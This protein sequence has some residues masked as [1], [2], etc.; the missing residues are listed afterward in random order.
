MITPVDLT[1]ALALRDREVVAL[2]GG[3][4][5]TTAMYLLC[6]E[7]LAR[8]RPAIAS[9]TARFTRPATVRAPMIVDE[10][11][12]RLVAEARRRLGSGEPWLV[13]AAGRGSKGRLLPLSYETVAALAAG[14]ADLV[15]L[16]ADGSALRPL[17][18]PAAH[19]PAVPPCATVV[20]AV[21]GADVLGRPLDEA[22]VHR[23]EMVAALSG[24]RQGEA[25]TA[26]TVAAVLSHAQGGRKALPPS[27]RF[28][29]LINK[30]SQGRLEGAR[31]TARLLLARGVA[32]VVLAQVRATEPVVDVLTV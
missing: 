7:A 23:P 20:I 11:G 31:D 14:P 26:A 25:V 1:D 24:A 27:A 9:G 19:E 32:R 6:H 13:L 17:K 29:V 2:V 15:V 12:P 4:G 30:V 22:H 10:D 16:E 21:V 28:V 18:A 3:G 8:G 5:K